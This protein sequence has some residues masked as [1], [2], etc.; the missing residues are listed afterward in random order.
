ML[1]ARVRVEDKGHQL[2]ADESCGWESGPM[3]QSWGLLGVA[4]MQMQMRSRIVAQCSAAQ[5]SACR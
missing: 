3:K 1:G 4:C 5:L 2:Q